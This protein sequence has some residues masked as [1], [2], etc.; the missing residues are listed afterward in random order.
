M[1]NL[2][3]W[4]SFKDSVRWRL[5][6]KGIE[7]EGDGVPRTRG[8]PATVKRIFETFKEPIEEMATKYGVPIEIIVATIATESGG[9]PKAVRQE[10]GYKSDTSTPNKVSP[11]L[12]QTLISTAE[13]VLKRDLTRDDLLNPR[14][15]IMAGTAYM[16]QQAKDTN[17]DPIKAGAAYNAGA[18][19]YQDGAKN[20]WKL[21]QYPIGT[22]AHCDRIVEFFNDTIAY[23]GMVGYA[24]TAPSY[25]K[26]I[27]GSA[28]VNKVEVVKELEK[29]EVVVVKNAKKSSTAG[30]IQAIFA[31][32]FGAPVATNTVLQAVSTTQTQAKGLFSSLGVSD[33]LVLSIALLA[34]TGVTAY[35]VLKQK[36]IIAERVEDEISGKTDSTAYVGNG[37]GVST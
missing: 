14:T 9:N 20:R 4:Q 1:I 29:K 24:G 30:W 22:S 19:Y 34:V 31:A 3:E 25:Y 11:G 10:P 36:G 35:I 2:N 27:N 23:L 8:E 6:P 28:P 16:A 13:G 12:M 18:M 32:V 5:T 7:V 26:Q 37:T 17:L 21:R 33:G 15:S